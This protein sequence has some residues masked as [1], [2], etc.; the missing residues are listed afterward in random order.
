MPLVLRPFERT[1]Q[2]YQLVE[3]IRQ[4]HMPDHQC[5]IASARQ[6]DDA[7]LAAHRMVERVV[8][9]RDGEPVGFAEARDLQCFASPERRL[10][11]VATTPHAREKGVGAQLMAW[12]LGRC[13]EVGA[14]DLL[15]TVSDHCAA[16]LR[17]AETHGF[18]T[19]DLEYEQ[20]A[21]PG[22]C[23]T[24][25]ESAAISLR[26]LTSLKTRSDWLERLHAL[27]E[28]LFSDVAASI[29]FSPRDLDAW[30]RDELGDP[31]SWHEAYLVA[32][33]DDDEWVGLTEIR[34]GVSPQVAH[35]WLT[36]VLPSHRHKGIATNLKA[37]SM[38]IANDAGVKRL[39]TSNLS[40]NE[41]MLSVNRR[42]GFRVTS[43]LHAMRRISGL[44]GS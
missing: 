31:K 17:F 18:K 20:L 6:Y 36:G 21:D 15:A 13:G 35:Q 43:T 25:P 34:R 40:T 41:P 5:T 7:G 3:R 24:V 2:E 14:T 22:Q 16:A 37:R 4:P 11:W 42:L 12:L 38:R 9:V 30:A 32:M 33:T 1:D 44:P 27:H 19:F 10:V 26:S 23:P 8:A 39:Y 29:D 28:R